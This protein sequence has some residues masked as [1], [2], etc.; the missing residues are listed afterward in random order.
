[1]ACNDPDN[2]D[3]TGRV[4]Q[5]SLP[6]SMLYLTARAWSI[7]SMR[8][9]PKLNDNWQSVGTPEFR[10]A[11]KRWPF[12]KRRSWVGNWCWD[13]FSMTTD[14]AT[15]FLIWLHRRDLFQ[16]E[17][18]WTEMADAWEKPAPLVLPEQWWVS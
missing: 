5:I 9:C 4:C 11:G 1:M 6:D 12:F 18:G 3:F 2:G 10:F 17:G 8:G 14:T 7:T 15:E 13:S 16:C